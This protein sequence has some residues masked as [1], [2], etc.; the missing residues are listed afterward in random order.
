MNML[1]L[2]LDALDHERTVRYGCGNLLQT[3]HGTTDL[4]GYTE[5]RTM[6]LWS[7][8]LAQQN[9]EAE[10][11]SGTLWDFSLP[12]QR[13]F[14]ADWPR[15]LVFDLPG[16]SYAAE[17]HARERALLKQ[18]FSERVGGRGA[19]SGGSAGQAPLS[20]DAYCAAMLEHHVQQERALFL[21]LPRLLGRRVSTQAGPA[22]AT[23]P[24]TPA[25]T[26]PD[27]ALI[28]AYFSL[29]DTVGHVCFGDERR[30]RSV[31]AMLD[32]LAGRIMALM[33]GPTLICSDHG[34][35]ALGRYGD[36]SREGFWS[37]NTASL[38]RPR[39]EE[40]Y[41]AFGRSALVTAAAG[42]PERIDAAAIGRT[43]GDH[44]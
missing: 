41:Q 24:D 17:L 3:H 43:P 20:E 28:V 26:A 8:F 15:H 16:Y 31:Y 5:P 1:I 6:V 42:F 25:S 27:D 34:M 38:G 7:S 21:E 9:V 37:T 13:T 23:S 35:R 40:L 2:A 44:G 30:M 36:H 10:V 4:S 33:P 11:M 18:Y 22:A 19:T 29:A 12:L 14:L 39:I 32:E